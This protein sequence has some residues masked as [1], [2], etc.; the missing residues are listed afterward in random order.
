[1]T[2]NTLTHPQYTPFVAPAPS[3]DGELYPRHKLGV[4]PGVHRSGRYAV[5]FAE[6]AAGGRFDA[7]SELDPAAAWEASSSAAGAL[8]M[9]TRVQQDLRAMLEPPTLQ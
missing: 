4:P 3:H 5:R 9:I 7:V 1:M 6:S 8:M 2:L